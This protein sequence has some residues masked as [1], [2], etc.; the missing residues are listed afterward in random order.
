M[1]G[2]VRELRALLGEASSI[3]SERF[4]SFLLAFAEIPQ[5]AGAD[6]GSF[7]ISLEYPDQVGPVIDLFG[8]EC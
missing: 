6:V 5:V 2:D 8:G 4:S 1:V 3:L 7:E